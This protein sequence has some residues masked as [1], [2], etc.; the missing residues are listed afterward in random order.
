MVKLNA[1]AKCIV[2]QEEIR[3]GQRVKAFVV[4]VPGSKGWETVAEGT[5]IGH[6]RIL[7]FDA[8]IE[9]GKIRVRVTDSFEKPLIKSI[10][11]Y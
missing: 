9:A 5:T 10:E 2:L 3:Y 7:R 1:P 11:L 8:P 6:K 4:E